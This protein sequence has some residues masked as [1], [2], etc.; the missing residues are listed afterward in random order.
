MRSYNFSLVVRL[1]HDKLLE[2]NK[3]SCRCCTLPTLELRCRRRSLHGSRPLATAGRTTTP[4]RA[5]AVESPAAG[6][7][8]IPGQLR[9]PRL[10]FLQRIPSLLSGFT[11]TFVAASPPFFRRYCH[12][13]CASLGTSL[14]SPSIV[15]IIQYVEVLPCRA[16][17][18]QQDPRTLIRDSTEHLSD[19]PNKHQIAEK[20]GKSSEPLSCT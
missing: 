20:R 1:C 9:S 8:A 10:S 14:G 16:E 11:G 6:I 7:V 3:A 4:A 18:V 12:N 17:K 13:C 19:T 15:F 2:F 5:T